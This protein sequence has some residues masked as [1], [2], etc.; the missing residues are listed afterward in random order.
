ML[1]EVWLKIPKLGKAELQ[2]PKQGE[3]R[4]WTPFVTEPFCY[5][6]L[7]EFR[8]GYGPFLLQTPK[9]D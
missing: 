8:S 3:V 7:S 5:R 2:T 4:L 9:L 6:T 1:G